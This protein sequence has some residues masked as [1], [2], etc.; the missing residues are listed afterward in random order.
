[1]DERQSQDAG[2]AA[3]AV[4][5]LLMLG[6]VI[7]MAVEFWRTDTVGTGPVVLLVGTGVLFWLFNRNGTSANPPQRWWGIGQELPTE[8]EARGERVRSYAADSTL[9]AVGSAAVTAGATLA[10]TEDL[11]LDAVMAWT[12]LTGTPLTIV[13]LLTELIGLWVIGFAAAYLMGESVSARCERALTNA[14]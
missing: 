6:T 14:D 2:T 8:P 9:F 4:L 3:Q 13:F 11:G 1:M 7:Y 5:G 10:G 12:G